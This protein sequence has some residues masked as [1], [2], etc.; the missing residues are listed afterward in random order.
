MYKYLIEVDHYKTELLTYS[1]LKKRA[2]HYVKHGIDHKITRYKSYDYTSYIDRI[3]NLN[4]AFGYLNNKRHIYDNLYMI[5]VSDNKVKKID[6]NQ[7]WK[8]I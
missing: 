4:F 1:E 8:E 7:F 5:V 6:I 2:E 3:F